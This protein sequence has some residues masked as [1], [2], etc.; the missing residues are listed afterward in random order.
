MKVD[1][2]WWKIVV[3]SEGVSQVE[4]TDH[5][6]S[7]SGNMPCTGQLKCMFCGKPKEGD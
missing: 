2:K 1:G 6:Y 3:W 7:W 5:S 4:C